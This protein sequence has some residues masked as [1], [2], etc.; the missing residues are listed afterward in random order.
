MS[1]NQWKPGDLVGVKSGGPAMTVA[2]ESQLGMVICEWFDG[3]K[4]MSDTFNAA[5]LEARLSP[6][7]AVRRMAAN[8]SR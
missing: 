7:E 1:E 6:A 4:K 8:R 2:G 5:V 3:K